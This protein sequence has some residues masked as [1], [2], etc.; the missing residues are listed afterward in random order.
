M[1]ANLEELIRD[2][3]RAEAQSLSTLVDADFTELTSAIDTIQ[4]RSG[5]VIV[6]G[7]GKSAIA[8]RKISATLNSTGTPSIFL[9]AAD[10]SHGDLGAVQPG[11]VVLVISKSGSSKELLSMMPHC[12][13]LSIPII[14]FVSK[15]T[16][17]LSRYARHTIYIPIA[18]EADP[19][20]VAPTSST[21]AHIAVGDALALALQQINGWSVES[22]A[23]LHPGG[24]LGNKLNLQLHHLHPDL[25]APRIESTA[26]I[27]Q[28]LLAISSGRMGAVAVMDADELVGIVT[29]GD[30]RRMLESHESYEQLSAVDIM[31]ANPKQVDQQTLAY[32]A[33]HLMEEHNISQVI[34]LA[35]GRYSGM[36]HLHDLLSV[37]F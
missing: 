24:A 15:E 31:T 27:K 36:V 30:L 35:D 25:K 14:A 21:I 28:T 1:K 29:D 37:G 22:F 11:D 4:S 10:A 23:R 2:T 3:L 9:H 7:V 5:R 13:K 33:L 34:V 32:D 6:T 16:A 18:R 17:E 8:A 19:N 26:S 12:Q 20:G